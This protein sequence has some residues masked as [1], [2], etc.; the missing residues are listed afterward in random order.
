M[1]TSC[2]PVTASHP[3]VSCLLPQPPAALVLQRSTSHTSTAPCSTGNVTTLV[4]SR[5]SRT[6]LSSSVPRAAAYNILFFASP[7]HSL[8]AS[9]SYIFFIYHCISYG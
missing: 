6:F 3:T 8:H 2:Y 4:L 9:H 1:G 7:S 5:Y